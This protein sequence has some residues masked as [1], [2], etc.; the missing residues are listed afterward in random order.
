MRFLLFPP[1]E[2]GV[3]CTTSLAGIA[4]GSC[5]KVHRFRVILGFHTSFNSY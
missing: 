1:E 5:G 3:S 2:T 4:T